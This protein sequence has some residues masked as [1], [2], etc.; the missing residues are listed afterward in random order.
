MYNLVLKV[1]K[2]FGNTFFLHRQRASTIR[3][4]Q[5]LVQL[6]KKSEQI[7]IKVSG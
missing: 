4:L 5:F 7:K 6:I 3:V 2:F 1:G